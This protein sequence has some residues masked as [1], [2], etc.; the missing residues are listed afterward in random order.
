MFR[1]ESRGTIGVAIQGCLHQGPVFGI[2][3]P[4]FTFGGDREPAIA[5]RLGVEHFPQSQQPIASASRHKRP[6][7]VAV[8]GGP[9]VA[10]AKCIARNPFR[11]FREAMH[12]CDQRSLPL[13]A[14]IGDGV[15]QAKALDFY[16]CLAEVFEVGDRNW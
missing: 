14:S 11:R 6:V 13:E 3:V 15:A 9:L 7:K 4:P 1:Y 5:F 2:K 16:T 12:C 10:Q 8:R